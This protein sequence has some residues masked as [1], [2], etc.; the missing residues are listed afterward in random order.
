MPASAT[1]SHFDSAIPN[2][3][4]E[5]QTNAQCIGHYLA[6]SNLRAMK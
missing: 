2:N 6:G 3:G 5:R 4:D 1:A